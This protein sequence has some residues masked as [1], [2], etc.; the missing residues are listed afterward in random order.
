MAQ[1]PASSGVA[2]G[3]GQLGLAIAGG[4]AL[5]VEKGVH[6]GG[7]AN[8]R[9]GILTIGAALDNDV[10]LIADKLSPHH[11]RLSVRNIWRGLLRIEAKDGPV[12][13]ADGRVIDQGRFLDVVMPA[14]FQLAAAE[15]K[16]EPAN[17]ISKAKKFALPAVLLAALALMLPP[18][19]GVISGL[20]SAPGSVMQVAAP[21]PL[22]QSTE[23]AEKFLEML[24]GRLREAGLTG[25]VSAD[26][27]GAGSLVATGTIEPANADKWRDV[28]KWYDAQPGA[29][30]LLNNVTRGEVN[31]VLPAFRAVWLDAKPQVVLLS[32][33]TAGVGETIGGGW[34]IEA[35]E[36][37]GVVLS[38]DGRTAKVAF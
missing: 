25:Q 8:N 29:P 31:A 1:K 34:K 28:I 3:L 14:R 13:L 16:A 23:Q 21:A 12:R 38:R 9:A 32:G 24:R 26:R 20:F 35:I 30:L 22:V 36:A 5:V 15:F 7:S 37:S 27:G 18:L 4:L 17:D 33:Q 11:A 10:V 19:T 6:A 2:D